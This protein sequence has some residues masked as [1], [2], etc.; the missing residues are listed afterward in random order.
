MGWF[1]IINTQTRKLLLNDDNTPYPFNDR[2]LAKMLCS[3][4]QGIVFITNETFAQW[5][6]N[7]YTA[8]TD[9]VSQA[10]T[11]DKLDP[12]TRNLDDLE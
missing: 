1:Y 11:Y 8:P 12:A 5:E 4:G 9:W 10:P 2:Y 6:G 3:E 7:D